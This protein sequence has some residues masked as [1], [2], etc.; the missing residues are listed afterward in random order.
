M[1]NSI[2]I[3]SKNSLSYVKAVFDAYVNKQAV[4]LLRSVNDQSR[5]EQVA[6]E[7]VVEPENDFGWFDAAYTFADDDTLAQISFT[8]GTE[9]E[10][11]GV[12][13]THRMLADVTTRLNNVMELGASVREY[14]GVPANFSF[15]LGRFRA[16][17]A[18]GGRSFLPEFGFNPVEIRDMLKAGEINA[19]SAVPTL[20]RVLLKNQSI[21]A[22]EALSL[23]W[24]EIGSQFMSGQEKSQLKTLFPNAVIA[25]HY[26]LTEASR[27][28]FLRI[29][30]ATDAQLESVGVAIG[31][32]KIKISESGR[33]CIQGEHVAEQLLVEG[34]YVDNVDTKGWLETSDLGYIEDGYLFF[35]GRADDLIN[36]AGI[37]LSP[38]ALEHD[39]RECLMIKGGIAIAAYDDELTGN[40]VLLAYQKS[41]ALDKQALFVALADILLTYGIHNK[42]VI[43][44]IPVDDFPLTA[45]GKVKRKALVKLYQHHCMGDDVEVLTE[46]AGGEVNDDSY[47]NENLTAEEALVQSIWQ[48]VLSIKHVDLGAN[49]YQLGGDSLTAISAV[50][51][52]EKM[53]DVPVEVAK[54]ILQGFTVREV[55]KQLSEQ[56]GREHYKHQINAPEIKA[57]MMI[58][59][60][61]G[62]LVLFVIGGHWSA[63][64]LERLP[65]SLNILS[66]Y[67]APAFAMGTPGF[68]IIYGVGAGFSLFPLFKSDPGRLKSI[69]RKTVVMLLAGIVILA[70]VK[71]LRM[72]LFGQSI[73]VTNFMGTFYSVLTYYF[74][75]SLSLFFWFRVISYSAR[76]AVFSV[77]LAII[78]YTL[79]TFMIRDIGLYR[80]EGV[81]EF[82]K[83]LL[84]AK[85][86]YFLMLNG[87]MLGISI[88]IL[89]RKLVVDDRES[90]GIYAMVGL[91]LITL[92]IVLSIHAGHESGWLVWPSEYNYIWR[93]VFYTGVVLL[94]LSIVDYLLA[95][96]GEY[97]RGIKFCFQFF[98]VIGML[99]FPLFIA[100][101]IVLPIKEMLSFYGMPAGAAL[102]IPM[103]LFMLGAYLL[104]RKV[105]RLSF[106]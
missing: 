86:S 26:G 10:P 5:I 72:F 99:A 89:T 38:D 18:I 8:S 11:K 56:S 50:V 27:S 55:A 42:Q 79:H 105:Y 29:D 58:N 51:A 33:I 15:G 22:D 106:L 45:T 19:V 88:G 70:A 25:Q 101:A 30:K 6:V 71:I 67:L 84:T 17:S 47:T 32:T 93:W 77:C 28:T 34:A 63:G 76:P 80:P 81:L 39:L 48:Q 69:L 73:T 20:W 104:F 1:M 52:I 14:V 74:L 103:L 57:G 82:L 43:K 31:T 12:L 66:V 46:G 91:S 97:Q 94:M 23:K 65:A 36:C 37:K 16:V 62:L 102:A 44:V 53:G 87:T 95:G 68:S 3:V 13:L 75:I 78:L 100:H 90:V 83:L 60:V 40:G 92:G 21:F 61:R 4:V 7:S 49:F 96:Y 85:Y 98:S 41:L 9:G 2:G 64:I 54:G 35:Q 59:V 24:I